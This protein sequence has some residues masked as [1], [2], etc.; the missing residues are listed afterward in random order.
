MTTTAQ[1]TKRPGRLVNFEAAREEHGSRADF[2]AEM[3]QVSDPLA[4]AVILE[5][6]EL[7]K[8]AKRQLNQGILHGLDSL[9]NPPPAITAFLTQIES[10][11]EWIDHDTVAA[12]DVP[13][14]SLPPVWKA[15]ASSGLSLAHV[16]ASPSI[17]K[18]LVQTG[19]LTTMAERRLVETGMWKNQTV[20]PG[21]LLRGA[22]G[23]VGTIQVRLLHARVRHTALKH[24][25]DSAKWGL[26]I[27]QTDVARTW[28]GFTIVPF[29]YARA[30]GMVFSEQE[31]AQHYRFWSYLAHV[32][33]LDERFHLDIRDD[34]AAEEL[35]DLLDS[36]IA[37]PD[38]NARALTEAMLESNAKTM[39]AGPLSMLDRATVRDLFNGVLRH[40]HGDRFAD[41]LHLPRS[42][43]AALLPLLAAVSAQSWQLQHRT[44]QT[45]AA[46]RE[47]FTAVIASVVAE[48]MPDH[49]AYQTHISPEAHAA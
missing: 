45:T 44:A 10:M 13:D 41:G 46:A 42:Q 49:T 16:Y 48:N 12:G 25:W 33:G 17:A 5:I 8:E 36:T 2:M 23:Y 27:N 40:V 43:N 34:A 7:G 30:F 38:D 14:L 47:E 32:L 28:F 39:S 4:D 35:L 21:S 22:P 29:L 3:L 20:L 11:P 9:D 31:Q 1:T 37:E 18:L 19:Q 26:P 15:L 6:N 24:G